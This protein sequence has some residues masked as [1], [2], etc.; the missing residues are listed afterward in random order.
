M[1]HLPFDFKT[2]YFAV[3]GIHFGAGDAQIKKAY[4]RMAR[5]YHPDVSKIH[6]AKEKFQEIAQAYEILK[7]YRDDY[8]DQ[9]NHHME[10]K[11]SK[12]RFDKNNQHATSAS[13]FSRGNQAG[14][15]TDQR[16]GSQSTKTKS[17][18]NDSHQESGFRWRYDFSRSD[19]HKPIAG[20]DREIEYPL[21]LRYAIRQ[22]KIGRFYV[23]GLK[24]SM[25]F[26]RLAFEGKTFRLA[27]K[28]YRGMFGGKDGDFLVRFKIR[29]DEQ[30]FELKSGD[31]YAKFF[32]S[33]TLL[34]AGNTII[35]DTPSGR[36]DIVLPEDFEKQSHFKIPAMG[37]P[38]DENQPAGDM[39]IQLFARQSDKS[40]PEGPTGFETAGKSSE[41]AV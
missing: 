14:F 3:L 5:R 2:D 9:Y 34:K 27:G 29:M 16:R 39:Y 12:S 30:R 32:V 40:P 17:K 6:G 19:F 18:S 22:L 28:G 41:V 23:P 31:I 36:V 13:R 24:V 15:R 25:T 11:R 37:L 10:L 35:L 20:K 8:C 21:T 38:A 1:S 26:N 4:R 7:K 33:K